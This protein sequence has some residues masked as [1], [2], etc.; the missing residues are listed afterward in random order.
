[1]RF[2]FTVLFLSLFSLSSFATQDYSE[3]MDNISQNSPTK[4][5][6]IL[7]SVICEEICKA[8]CRIVNGEQVC[9]DSCKTICDE[10]CN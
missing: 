5:T 7:C 2:I 8:D 4:V 10:V 3:L 6:P 1:M 9:E